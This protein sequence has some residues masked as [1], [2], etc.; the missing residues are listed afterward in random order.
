MLYR[1]SSLGL[2]IVFIQYKDQITVLREGWLIN[3]KQSFVKYECNLR[4]TKRLIQLNMGVR[5]I[6]TV[7]VKGASLGRHCHNVYM[8]RV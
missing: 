2:E 7:R 8:G 4:I 5:I 3:A 1:V 6:K